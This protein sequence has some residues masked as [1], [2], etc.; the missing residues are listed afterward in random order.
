MTTSKTVLIVAIALAL[1]LPAAGANWTNYS[2]DFSGFRVET[3]CAVHSTFYETGVNPLP[4]PYLQY[5]GNGAARGLLFMG[6]GDQPAGLGYC[7]SYDA[8]QSRRMIVGTFTLDVA[9]PCDSQVGQN[10]PGALY[11]ATSHDGVAW[12]P[13]QSLWSGRQSIPIRSTEGTCYI[14]FTGD[15]VKIDNVKVTLSI[16]PA[17]ITV[18]PNYGTTIQQ[19]IDSARTGDII[20][21]TAGTYTGSGNWD[22]DFRG[23]RITVRSTNGPQSTTIVCGS[24]HRGF[25]FHQGETSDSVLSGFTIR[26]GRFSGSNTLGGG[27]YCEEAGPTIVN[28]V[29]EECSAGLGGGIACLGGRPALL[30]CTIQNCSAT[31]AGSG[32]YL[33]DT[34]A[35]LAGCTISSNSGS[36][37]GG[38][39]Y[40]SGVS[41]DTTFSNCVIANNRAVAGG[42]IL[43]E[44][45]TGWGQQCRLSI[46]NCTIL[47]NRLTSTG[48]AGGV[49]AG[50]ADVAIRNSIIWN[51]DG[52]GVAPFFAVDVSYSNVQGD[53]WGEGNVSADPE[54]A[55]SDCHLSD[56]SPCIDAGD[57]SSPAAGEPS[58]NGGRI[59]MGAFG[60]TVEAAKSPRSILHV[61]NTRIQPGSYATIQEAI[62]RA[63]DGDIILVWPGVYEE[64]I[65]FQGKAITVQSAADAAV[66]TGPNH[67]CSFYMGEGAGSVL[68]NFVITGCSESGIF[69]NGASPTLKNLTIV[70]NA[71]GIEGFGG[72]SPDVRNCIVWGNPRAALFEVQAKYSCIEPT[73]WDVQV[74][75]IKAMIGNV[76]S[77]PL[78]ADPSNG[79]YHLKSYYG[80]YN[81]RSDTWGK[82]SQ[83]ILSPCIDKGDPSDDARNEPRGN[84]E[85]I[86]MGAYGGTR[87]ASKSGEATCP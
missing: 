61:D 46:A 81:P 65:S 1:A 64:E 24:G 5:H 52:T 17:A 37:R 32:V 49:D 38:G 14:L 31:S 86:N 77:D 41:L 19:A 85:R 8:A 58:P 10:P 71:I 87:Y 44:R 54:F 83:K 26:G 42:G 45:F 74:N 73:S 69:C 39:A 33:F 25:Y 72:A 35:T 75:N 56:G 11:Y 78:F 76:S 62:D 59:D 70:K 50:D 36:A 28:C 40:C 23:K 48:S 13:R 43:A 18:R 12:S 63:R 57:P 34:E 47:E 2:D 30:S 4:A 79:D 20:E 15:R 16:A 67:A 53:Y 80:R 27:I 7:L 21:V 6:C 60:G 55:D 66:L 3:D 9:F 82:D 29:V 51:N 22:I 68:K 84:G